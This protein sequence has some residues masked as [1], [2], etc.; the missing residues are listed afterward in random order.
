M[1]YLEQIEL[2][3][4][5]SVEES[6]NTVCSDVDTA[7]SDYLTLVNAIVDGAFGPNSTSLTRD[8]IETL[9]REVT[10]ISETLSDVAS[11]INMVIS[12]IQPD[13]IDEEDRLAE[14]VR[15][16]EV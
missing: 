11:M 7:T 1:E 10:S 2:D 15:N 5:H 12:Y 9:S 13:I 4:A 16:G 8:S 14:K 3:E 6:L